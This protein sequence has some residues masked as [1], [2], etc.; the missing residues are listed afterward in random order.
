MNSRKIWEKEKSWNFYNVIFRL[1]DR[2]R[3]LGTFRALYRSLGNIFKCAIYFFRHFR[4]RK[5]EFSSI[6]PRQPYRPE[7]LPNEVRLE[8]EA[9]LLDVNKDRKNQL[10]IHAKIKACVVQKDCDPV[11]TLH[12]QCCQIKCGNFRIFCHSDF[13]WN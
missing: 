9:V 3:L 10:W 1:F 12:T 11:S 4:C 7:T 5:N 2:G 8:F 6:V 13:T